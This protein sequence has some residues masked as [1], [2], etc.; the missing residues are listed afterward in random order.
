MPAKEIKELRQLGKLEEALTMAKAELEVQPDNIWGKRNISW[1]YYDYLK[2]SVAQVDLGN[3]ISN[4]SAIKNL[5]LP[6][7]EKMLFDNLSWQIG[8]MLFKS[9]GTDTLH[10]SKLLNLI[11]ISSSFAYTK[12]SEGYSFLFKAFHKALKVD[13]SYLNFANWWDFDNFREEDYK[14]DTLPDGKEVMAIAEQA[15]IAYAKRLLPIQ[16]PDGEVIFDKEKALA[17]IKKLSVLE[18]RQPEYQY[19]AYFK[20]KLLLAVGDKEH[21][22]E[23]LLPFAKKKRNDFW[24]W[25]ILAEAFSSDPN[26]VFACYCKALSCKSPEEMLVGLRQKIAKILISKTYL[27]EAKTEIEFLVKSRNDKGFKIPGE[28]LN[29]QCQEW[30]KNA[31][32][33]KSNNDLYKKFVPEAEALLFYDVPEELIIVDYVNSDK[34]ILNFIASEEKF[35]F[36]KYDRFFRDVR[37]GDVLKVRFQG[38]VNEGMHQTYT[39]VKVEEVNFKKKFMKEVEGQIKIPFGKNFGFVNDIFIQPSIITKLNL[40][41]GL[42]FS[43]VAIKSYN[44]DK[45]LWS[46]KVI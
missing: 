36:L 30:F 32:V 11:E 20:A 45:K 28:V 24:V 14:K 16:N 25:E 22:L 21:M 35:G 17:F 1:V 8:S 37:I 43:G 10:R 3:F 39:I 19:P 18:E 41:D 4:L 44:K 31:S 40:I 6:A 7:E 5:E 12:P 42:S 26:K 13:S 15:Y 23:S 34:K 38:G 46:W 29:W 33:L 9:L 27:S 2:Q